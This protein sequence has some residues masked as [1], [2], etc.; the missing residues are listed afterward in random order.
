MQGSESL[1]SRRSLHSV[2]LPEAGRRV[3]R[4]EGVQRM[5]RHSNVKT[6]GVYDRRNY[7]SPN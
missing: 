3:G 7:D 6:T 4:I 5:T 1:P 2:G